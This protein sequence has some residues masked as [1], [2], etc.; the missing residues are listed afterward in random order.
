MT[1][2]AK[3]A[4]GFINRYAQGEYPW[5][6]SV[7]LEGELNGFPFK[8]IFPTEINR[9]G[10]LQ[11]DLEEQTLLKEMGIIPHAKISWHTIYPRTWRDGVESLETFPV[12]KLSFLEGGEGIPLAEEYL[13]YPSGYSLG[14][15]AQPTF[16]IPAEIASSL[17]AEAHQKTVELRQFHTQNLEAFKASGDPGDY[18]P[19]WRPCEYAL[20]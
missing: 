1:L 12:F 20:D 5:S 2:I 6:S 13:E 7:V 4:N 11:V 18:Y 10:P 17:E 16:S 8:Y 9:R 19:M 3:N 15:L 14:S